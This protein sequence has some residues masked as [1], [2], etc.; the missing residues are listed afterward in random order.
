MIDKCAS[1]VETNKYFEKMAIDPSKLRNFDGLSVSALGA[2]T[3]LGASDDATDS[4]YEKALVKAALAGINFFDTA[5]NYRNG[6]SE[7]VL[8]K[9]IHA[10]ADQG[11]SR[12]ELVISTKG[13]IIPFE[14][15]FEDYVR[16]HFLDTG[17]IETKDIVADSQCMTPPFLENQIDSSLTNL[18]LKCI[19]LYYLHNP[20]VILAEVGEEEFYERLRKCFDLFERKVNDQKIARYGIASW[21][22]FRQKKGALNLSK[23]LKCAQD[24]AGENHHLKAIQMPYNLV[25]LEAIKQKVIEQAAEK[26]IAVMI[27]APLMQSQVGQINRRIFEQLPLSRSP[28]TQSLEFVL[29]TPNVCSTFCGM[30]TVAH[31]EENLAV[32]HEPAWSIDQWIKASSLLGLPRLQSTSQ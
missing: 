20:E 8:S 16:S 17:I 5:I 32:M 26:G 18:N 21:N 6:R 4:L 25:M 23:V 24:V 1:P 11:V 3:Y 15:V 19:D 13:G 2:G 31:L 28:L 22:G 12:E 14:G 10:L 29:S 7:K 9:V 27:S 30:K